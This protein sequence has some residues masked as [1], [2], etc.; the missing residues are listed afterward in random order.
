MACR[1]SLNTISILNAIESFGTPDRFLTSIARSVTSDR[2]TSRCFAELLEDWGCQ[3]S[4]ILNLVDRAWRLPR[5]RARTHRAA[6]KPPARAEKV[7][8]VPASTAR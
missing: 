4:P 2:D 3:F 6:R 5:I 7:V 1:R 8:P